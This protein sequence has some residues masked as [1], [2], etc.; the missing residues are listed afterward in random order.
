MLTYEST[1]PWAAAMKEAVKTHKMPPWFA[2]RHYAKFTNGHVLSDVKIKTIS[3]WADAKAPQGDPKNLPPIHWAEGW[4]IGTPDKVYE[5]PIPFDVAASGLVE[6][7]HI[8][9]PTGFTKD[10]WVQAAEVCPTDRAE[11]RH[12]IAFVR[13]PKSTWFPDQPPGQFF[14]SSQKKTEEQPDTRA[15]PSDFLVG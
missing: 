12:I 7:Q 13:G 2:D 9:V 5:L 4:E 8:I 14:I 1:R 10:M 15:L 11:V 6:Y 3:D